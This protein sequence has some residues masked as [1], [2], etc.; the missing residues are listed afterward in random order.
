[1]RQVALVAPST[2]EADGPRCLETGDVT[3]VYLGPAVPPTIPRDVDLS[4]SL[5]PYC[6]DPADQYFFDRHHYPPSRLIRTVHPYL[7]DFSQ[8]VQEPQ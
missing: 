1:V 7:A 4:P 3:P 2:D 8:K 6:P 5:F